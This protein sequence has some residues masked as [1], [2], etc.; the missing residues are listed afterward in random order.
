MAP[1]FAADCEVVVKIF[2]A[3][4]F[5]RYF[6]PEMKQILDEE[7]YPD[8]QSTCLTYT[9][10]DEDMRHMV[11]EH[12]IGGFEIKSYQLGGKLYLYPEDIPEAKR[13]SAKEVWVYAPYRKGDPMFDT[14]D[15]IR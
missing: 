12:D 10:V 2:P 1:G 4:D 13:S 8:Y 11:K 7:V 14:V 6:D 5:A 9:G 3:E 15:E